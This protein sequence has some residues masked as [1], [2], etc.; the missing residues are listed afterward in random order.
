M[1]AAARCVAHRRE[2]PTTAGVACSRSRS[3]VGGARSGRGAAL[4]SLSRIAPAGSTAEAHA[5]QRERAVL[6][7][8]R[9]SVQRAAATGSGSPWCG[10]QRALSVSVRSAQAA[11]SRHDVA[12]K[13]CSVTAQPLRS[14]PAC[15]GT[16]ARRQRPPGWRGKVIEVDRLHRCG[17]LRA[18]A[19]SSAQ[20]PQRWPFQHYWAGLTPPGGRRLKWPNLQA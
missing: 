18:H 14:H 7:R 4:S 15:N 16:R 10:K 9:C 2:Q 1:R 11:V 20:A 12:H 5:W 8:E 17:S 6:A 13:T 3:A 19:V